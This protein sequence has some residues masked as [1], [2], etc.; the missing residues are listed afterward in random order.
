MSEH[1]FHLQKYR[2]G[3]KITCPYCERTKCFTRYIDEQGEI[4]F[5]EY[6][7]RCDHEGRCGVNYTPSMYFQD[8]PDAKECLGKENQ[9]YTRPAPLIKSEH[10]K[11]V[12]LIDEE[13]VAQ[14]MKH[15][16][17]NP[18]YQYFCRIFGEEETASLFSL[19]SVGTSTKWGGA[20][21]FWQKDV[22]GKFRTG[23]VMK[24]D[25]GNGHRIKEPMAHVSWAHSE[26]KLSAFNLKQCLFGEHLLSLYPDTPV[27]IV[28]SEKTAIVCRHFLPDYLWLA[29]GGKNGCFNADAMQVLK[30]RDVT[31]FP[32]LGAYSQ[33]NAKA[34]MLEDICHTVSV[35]DYIERVAT[36]Q[37]REAGWDIAD[38]L[39]LTPT[40][41][42]ILDRMIQ[43]NPVLQLLIDKLEL[44]LL[45]P[46]DPADLSAK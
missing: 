34:H 32:D 27:M 13:I 39:L 33:W 12:S 19:Y 9:L 16:S 30:G 44:E 31:L 25:M 46:D 26:L 23:K 45:N 22:N 11:S 37:Q 20:T 35:S 6:V 28:E 3:S 17:I 40:S 41:R 29:T 14:S 36:D 1:R 8:N 4:T 43:R 38:F 15:Y 24:Y 42:V 18:L 5:P 2:H 10:P 7:G 21:V